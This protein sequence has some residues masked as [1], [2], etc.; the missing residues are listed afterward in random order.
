MWLKM[1]ALVLWTIWNLSFFRVLGVVS[2]VEVVPMVGLPFTV[3]IEAAPGERRRE[4][5]EVPVSSFLRNSR[6]EERE[7]RRR[8]R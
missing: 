8:A 1:H 4:R 7:N 5:D 6:P 3:R 2:L